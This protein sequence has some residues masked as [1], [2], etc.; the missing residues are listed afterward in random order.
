MKKLLY[1]GSSWAVRS[2]DRDYEYPPTPTEVVGKDY[3]NLAHELG[4]DVVNLAKFDYSNIDCYNAI[5]NYDQSFDGV[6]WIYCDPLKDLSASRG[7]TIEDFVKS[8]DIWNIQRSMN[9][10][11]L[12]RISSLG[13]PIALIGGPGDVADADY[14]NLTV[15]HPSW[16][17]FLAEL[18]NVTLEVGCDADLL[19]RYIKEFST[20]TPSNELIKLVG[21]TLDSWKQLEINKVFKFVHPNSKGTQFFANHIRPS[22]NTWVANL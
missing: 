21:N 9:N 14:K 7:Y 3:T 2:F 1:I 5:V 10:Y 18:V 22:L 20:H 17:K 6:V 12:K 11:I 19:Q 15:I 16:Q 4:I 13:C 8:T